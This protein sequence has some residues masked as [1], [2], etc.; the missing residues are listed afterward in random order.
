MQYI[1]RITNGRGGIFNVYRTGSSKHYL[2]KPLL[3]GK[4]ETEL[5][6]PVEKRRLRREIQSALAHGWGNALDNVY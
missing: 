5:A 2:F 4:Y 1:A 6:F 3:A